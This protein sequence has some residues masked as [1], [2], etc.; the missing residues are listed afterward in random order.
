MKNVCRFC[1]LQICCLI[2]CCKAPAQV[3]N[4]V[5]KLYAY[6]VQTYAGNVQT[7][8][9]G[10]EITPGAEYVHL[11]FAETSGKYLPQ[12]NMVFTNRGVY[13]IQASEVESGKLEVGVLKADT[14]PV[15][16]AAKRGNRL[17]K[18]ELVPVKSRIPP[19]I[20]ALLTTNDVVVTSEW[21]GQQFNHPVAKEIEL[22]SIHYK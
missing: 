11:V 1:L 22:A 2:L 19:D 20:E 5:A 12:W 16:I 10:N 15:H 6:G 17:W 4:N 21:K 9:A 7:D 8:S 14:K 13:A 18:L 3:K